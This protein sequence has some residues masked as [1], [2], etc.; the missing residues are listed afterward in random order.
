[1][2][3]DRQGP[4]VHT[5][6]AADSA[7]LAWVTRAGVVES[8][9]IGSM[10][11]VAPDGRVLESFGAPERSIFPRS[12]LKPFQAVASLRAGALISPEAVA[13]AC[14][15]HI[16]TPRHQE[17]AASVLEAEKLDVSHLKCPEAYPQREKDRVEHIAAGRE[18]TKLAFNCSGKHAAFL[19]A[20]RTQGWRLATYAEQHHPLQRIVLQVIEEYCE[21]TPQVVGVDGC[22]APAPA[23]SLTGLARGFSK[24]ASATSRRDAE[25]HAFTVN[26]AMLDYSWAVHGRGEANTVVMEDLGVLAK[27]GAEGVLILGAQDGTT[28]AVKILDGSG[29]AAN[30]VALSL[31]AAREVVDVEDLAPVLK[32][33]VHPITGGS[34]GA[35]VGSL[36]LAQDLLDRL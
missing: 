29:R 19:A 14:G 16:G 27:L 6:S 10:V 5:A 32:K 25:V 34:D 26:Q 11:M 22:G 21:E 35:Q 20:T 3:A 9:H 18:K 4:T 2:S 1:M 36:R 23:V 31:L 33:I 24:I 12:T 15:S 30:L 13:L 7:E 17:L 8:R 28:V